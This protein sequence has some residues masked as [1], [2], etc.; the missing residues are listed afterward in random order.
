MTRNF[1]VVAQLFGMAGQMLMDPAS[2]YFGWSGELS[3]LLHAL[4]GFGQA[5]M[6][7]LAHNYNA[8]G[9]KSQ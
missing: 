2:K 5:A 9:S 1:Q 7:I 4:I 8:D 3:T 6:G